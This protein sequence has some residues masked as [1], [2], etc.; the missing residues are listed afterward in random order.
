MGVTHFDRAGD[1]NSPKVSGGQ[2]KHPS[3]NVLSVSFSIEF[4][5]VQQALSQRIEEIRRQTDRR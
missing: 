5:F 1:K 3:K 2:W 4:P